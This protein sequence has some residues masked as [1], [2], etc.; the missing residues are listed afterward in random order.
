VLLLPAE[1]GAAV[2]VAAAGAVQRRWLLPSA[3]HRLAPSSWLPGSRSVR[4]PSRS[5]VL[6]VCPSQREVLSQEAA[7]DALLLSH[8]SSLEP[9]F[10]PPRS[11]ILL[12]VL[13]HFS[14]PGVPTSSPQL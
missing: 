3:F 8:L 11:F 4:L 6:G 9:L 12:L 2:S 5:S 10:S 1:R 13:L 14:W 7:L